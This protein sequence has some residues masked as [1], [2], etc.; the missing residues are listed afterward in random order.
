MSAVTGRGT[1]R[2]VLA[3]LLAAAVVLSGCSND[4][5]EASDVVSGQQA[6]NYTNEADQQALIEKRYADLPSRPAGVVDIDGNTSESLTGTEATKY[7]D[8]GTATVLNV[9]DNGEDRAF[10]RLCAGEIDLV[11]ST[12]QISRAEWDACRANGL[13]VIQ[14]QIAADAVVVAIKSETDVGGDCLDTDQVQDIYRAGS[15]VT[16]WAQV[17]LN[18]VPLKVG[19]PDPANESFQ[20]FG[21]T[22]LDAPDPGLTNFRSDYRV[23]DSD[24]GTRTFVVGDAKAARLARTYADRARRRDLVKSQVVTAWQVWQDAHAEVLIAVAE[25]KKGIRDKRSPAQRAR[26]DARVA[27]AYEAQGRAITRVHAL[28]VKFKRVVARFEIARDARR[29]TEETRGHVAYFRFSYYELFEDQ[30]RP[31][32]ITVPTGERNCIFPSQRTIT[33]GEYPLSRQLL[34]TTT[35]RSLARKE[36]SDF[37]LDY[38]RRARVQAT[39]ARLVALPVATIRTQKRWL[40]GD[41]PPVLV[42]PADSPTATTTESPATTPTEIPAR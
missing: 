31:F 42:A 19:G 27:A 29:V 4:P 2:T 12:R 34:M 8:T 26:D 17:G 24:L 28:Q 30:L 37:L 38:L 22:V 20:F 21:R 1:R 35:S 40:T 16:S 9:A 33:S 7:V 41:E 36:V 23:F 10:Q 5:K 6:Q 39:D 32:E 14:F 3:L 18:D 25:Q 13:D 15:P 11:D